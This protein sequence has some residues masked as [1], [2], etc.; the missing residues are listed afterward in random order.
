[1]KASGYRHV[2]AAWH[3]GQG[4]AF[5]YWLVDWVGPTACLDTVKEK[6]LSV[7]RGIETAISR[8]FG[9]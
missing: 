5:A 9:P 4:A 3:L 6:D 2:P 1:M 8:S 7:L